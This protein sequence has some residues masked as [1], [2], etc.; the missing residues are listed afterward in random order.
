MEHAYNVDYLTFIFLHCAI[1]TKLNSIAGYTCAIFFLYF[2]EKVYSYDG[3][4]LFMVMCII[5]H[6]VC[7]SGW[8]SLP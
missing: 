7:K 1:C 2:I 3:C 5:R 6:C 4:L 8:V